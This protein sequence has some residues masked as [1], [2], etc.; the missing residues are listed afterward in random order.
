MTQLFAIFR[1]QPFTPTGFRMQA[2]ALHQPRIM[3][4][5]VG[6]LCVC[7]A[8]ALSV[9]GIAAIYTVPRPREPDYA[10]RQIVF[11]GAG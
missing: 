4:S 1:P 5:N 2:R 3:W 7:T 11:L 6:W 8:V 10:M 9:L